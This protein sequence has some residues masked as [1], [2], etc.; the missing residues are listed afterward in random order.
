MSVGWKSIDGRW[1][2]MSI[3]AFVVGGFSLYRA[4]Q[5]AGFESTA[6]TTTA[7][8]VFMRLKYHNF[9]FIKLSKYYTC[10]YD[11]TVEGVYYSG[12][13]DCTQ[14]SAGDSLK[15]SFSD[16]IQVLPMPDLT[17]Y[18]NPA[19]PSL[20]SLTEFGAKSKAEY[21]DGIRW[22]SL[23]LIINLPLIYLAIYSANRNRSDRRQY[24]DARGTV[25]DTE[26]TDFGTEFGWL[27]GRSERSEEPYTTDNVEAAKVNDFSSSWG[28]REL[29]LDV[30]KQIHPDHASSETD[31]VLRERLTKE[32]NL[33]FRRGDDATLRTVLEEYRS[34]ILVENSI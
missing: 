25:I 8:H 6:R 17:V 16:S 26:G 3:L 21:R 27:P 28:L 31:R 13:G 12:F 10:R 9:A 15:K 24:V 29:Y 34:T 23:G 14:L 7:Y 33:A 11:F 1:M 5:Y 22:I 4:T 32:A 19:D 30:I 2:I 18:Y 20:N